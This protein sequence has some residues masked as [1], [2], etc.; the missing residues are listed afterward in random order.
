MPMI[1]F[2]VLVGTAAGLLATRLMRIQTDLLTPVVLGIVGA[3][4]GWL[5]LRFVLALS[6]WL[7]MA[8]AATLGAVA[9]IWLWQKGF[10]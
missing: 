2:L 7:I 3:G 8:L 9:V 4:I 6:G 10:K 1:L 5:A